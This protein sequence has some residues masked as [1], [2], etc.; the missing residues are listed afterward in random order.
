[1]H[2]PW[3]LDFM[4]MNKTHFHTELHIALVIT[5]RDKHILN[6]TIIRFEKFYF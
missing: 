1:M 4:S 6:A 5:L 2:I 3:A